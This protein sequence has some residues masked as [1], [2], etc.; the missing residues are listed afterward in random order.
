MLL[1]LLLACAPLA[2]ESG[3]STERSAQIE[4][5]QA[6]LSDRGIPSDDLLREAVVFGHEQG[7]S[8]LRLPAFPAPGEPFRLL[9]LAD[10][11]RD[12]PRGVSLLATTTAWATNVEVRGRALSTSDGRPLYL[13]GPVSLPASSVELAVRVDEVNFPVWLNNNTANY[14]FPVAAPAPV[15]WAG[16]V[17]AT[18]DLQTRNLPADPLFVGHDLTLWASTYPQTGGVEVFAQWTIDGVRQTDVQGS[19]STINGGQFGNDSRWEIELPT[20]NLL[21]GQVVA[22]DVVVQ[23]AGPDVVEDNA[24]AHYTGT[25]AAAPTVDWWDTGL[26]GFSACHWDGFT[27]FTGWQWDAYLPT[28]L[29]ASP[30]QFQAGAWAPIPGV[31][32]FVPGVTDRFDYDPAALELLKVEVE[33]PFFN[34]S[35]TAA[36][37]TWPLTYRTRVGNN[38]Q[39]EWQVRQQ[40]HPLMLPNGV[41]CPD[42][43]AYPF[44]FRVS[45]D[46]GATWTILGA[47]AFPGTQDGLLLWSNFYSTPDFTTMPAGGL[48]SLPNTAVGQTSQSTLTLVNTSNVPLTLSGLHYNAAQTEFAISYPG[49]PDIT[50]C[51]PVVPSGAQ[52]PL[53]VRFRPVA[54]GA[55]T[56]SLLGTRTG[57]TGCVNEGNN[58]FTFSGT[59]L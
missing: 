23:S 14:P 25:F 41:E 29:D 7:W 50:A 8:L 15:T 32:L 26:W 53:T 27:C 20:A 13:W 24:G 42:A 55:R 44:H 1:S 37:G 4:A 47:A 38:L 35:P 28:P 51:T 12:P 33:S 40:Y 19:L 34:G 46:G 58:V 11:Q 39:Y 36:P 57:G 49:C 56:A 59:G 6:T 21:P 10:F 2:P 22:A 17:V 16:D 45:T 52:L 48:L 30:G 9:A 3:V 54:A 18:L 31:E 5:L 43:G